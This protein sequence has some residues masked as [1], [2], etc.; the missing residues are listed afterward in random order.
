MNAVTGGD[1]GPLD[2]IPDGFFRLD[3]D[4]RLEPVNRAARELLADG[5]TDASSLTTLPLPGDAVEQLRAGGA[6]PAV[7]PGGR[8]VVLQ[9]RSDAA[10]AS[11][12]QASDVTMVEALHGQ[13]AALGRLRLLGGFAQGV[14]HD[15][16]NVLGAAIGIAERAEDAAV[17]DRAFVQGL[18]ASARSGAQLL[19]TF[20]RLARSSPRERRIVDL[21]SLA[22]DA[23][24]LFGKSAQK[25]GC[26]VELQVLAAPRVRV[27]VEDAMQLVLLA[28][29]MALESAAGGLQTLVVDEASSEAAARLRQFGRIRILDRG[30]A[31]AFDGLAMALAAPHHGVLAPVAGLAGDGSA[32]LQALLIHLRH[33]G[34]CRV[35]TVADGRRELTLAWPAVSR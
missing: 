13:L 19:R 29:V 9:L 3:A 23:L 1:G 24:G 8:T 21:G 33:G 26:A 20:A 12:L 2:W 5:L 28:C 14:A 15:L 34:Y 32:L 17:E 7:L 6:V 11:W 35:G 10:G 4:G 25:R 31:A 30:P 27:I 18:L 16:N 22:A